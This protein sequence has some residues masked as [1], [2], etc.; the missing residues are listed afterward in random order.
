MMVDER[1]L[2]KVFDKIVDFCLMAGLWS[3]GIIFSQ[4]VVNSIF[5]EE[6]ER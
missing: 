6:R 2:D 4:W 1:E 3:L 5:T